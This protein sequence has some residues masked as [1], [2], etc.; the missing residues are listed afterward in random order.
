V[1]YIPQNLMQ[2]E[3]G[4]TARA[5]AKQLNGFRI[6][7]GGSTLEKHVLLKIFVY[8]LFLRVAISNT[9]Y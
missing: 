8:L 1:S 5:D 9:G 2:H 7:N 6:S 4:N 3:E